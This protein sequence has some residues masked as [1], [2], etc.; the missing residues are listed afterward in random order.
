M[1]THDVSV[2]S[3][4]S[5]VFE[6]KSTCGNPHLG[7]EDFDNRLINYCMEEFKKKHKI[8]LTT[9]E[10]SKLNKIRSRLHAVCERAKR[11]LSTS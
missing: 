9:I 6:V 8:D 1:G 7:G 2:L 5:G 10:K 11:N 4:D 3:L